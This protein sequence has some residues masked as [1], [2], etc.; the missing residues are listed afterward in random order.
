MIRNK[1]NKQ[2]THKCEIYL[3]W[4]K[5]IMN[6]VKFIL[7]DILPVLGYINFTLYNP[8]L[9]ARTF[10]PIELCSKSLMQRTHS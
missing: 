10:D 1:E 7:F 2:R 8:L 3:V 9:Y 5:V 4:G 6:L